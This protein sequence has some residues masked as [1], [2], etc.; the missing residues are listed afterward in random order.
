[1]AEGPVGALERERVRVLPIRV[2]PP[3]SCTL[4]CQVEGGGQ[5]LPP[6]VLG[7]GDCP[8]PPPSARKSQ[9]TLMASEQDGTGWEGEGPVRGTPC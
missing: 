8:L 6:T 3:A 7:G 9:L 5:L 4:C 1:M 2:G